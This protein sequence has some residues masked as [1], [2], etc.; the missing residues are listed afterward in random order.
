MRRLIFAAI[1]VAVSLL[2]GEVMAKDTGLPEYVGIFAGRGGAVGPYVPLERLTPVQQTRVRGF[3]FGG[4]EAHDSFA[5]TTSPVR[6]KSGPVE[7]IVRVA[8]Q[9]QDPMTLIQFFALKEGNAERFL[10]LVNVGAFAVHESDSSRGQA[11]AFTATKYGANFFKIVPS[12][13]LPP[14]EYMLGSAA[15]HDGF[16]FGID[17]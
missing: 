6:F 17:P 5:G 8:S 12:Q 1:A 10:P 7:F 2:S 11:I 13:P 16:L 3:G 4:A 14:G 9:D 15:G